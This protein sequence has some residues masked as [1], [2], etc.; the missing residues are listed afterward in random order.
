MNAPSAPSR[1]KPIKLIRRYVRGVAVPSMVLAGVTWI[2]IWS[3]WASLPVPA[4]DEV[5]PGGQLFDTMNV[6][7][8]VLLLIGLTGAHD[9]QAGRTRTAGASSLALLWIGACAMGAWVIGLVDNYLLFTG[10]VLALL[11]GLAVLSFVWIRARA[12]PR[13][14]IVPLVV[15]L[16]LF[17]LMNPDDWRALIALPMGASW[18]WL[19]FVVWRLGARGQGVPG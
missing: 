8:V 18:I 10:G 14:A 15:G 1:S 2:V 11:I 7:A 12:L 16:L 17:P 4:A 3:Y 6:I 5:K 9:M 13:S 19:G